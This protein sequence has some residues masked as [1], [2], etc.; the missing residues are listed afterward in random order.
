MTIGQDDPDA[1]PRDTGVTRAID[2][3]RLAL[4]RVVGAGSGP[5]V[6]ELVLYV[7]ESATSLRA[8]RNLQRYFS[9]HSVDG[10]TLSVRDLSREPLGDDAEE[11]RVTFTPLLVK[12]MPPPRERLLGDLHH[13]R[14]LEE[15]L[16]PPNPEF[17]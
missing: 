14:S 2:E 6:I 9:S 3:A 1:P 16:V 8:L 15:L 4:E 17:P 7:T 10:V 13:V 11:D 5:A 12:R